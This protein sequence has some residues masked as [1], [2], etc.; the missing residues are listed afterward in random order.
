V[1]DAGLASTQRAL[2]EGHADVVDV[3]KDIAG[4]PAS[5]KP[6]PY[7]VGASGASS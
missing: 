2:L 7:L 3:P 1:L 6:Y 4:T 5:M